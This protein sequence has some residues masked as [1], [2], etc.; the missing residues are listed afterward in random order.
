MILIVT[1]DPF[2]KNKPPVCNQQMFTEH[3]VYAG[4]I[5]ALGVNE[6]IFDSSHLTMSQCKA[7]WGE[8]VFRLQI[9]IR[10]NKYKQQRSQCRQDGFEEKNSK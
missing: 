1:L 10:Q 3:P 9:G 2:L 6:L 4:D 5:S 8:V 7:I